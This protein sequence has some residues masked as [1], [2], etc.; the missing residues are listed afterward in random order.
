MRITNAD[1]SSV[2]GDFIPETADKFS[3]TPGPRNREENMSQLLESLPPRSFVDFTLPERSD[4]TELSMCREAGDFQ[5]YVAWLADYLHMVRLPLSPAQQS[6][7][8][9]TPGSPQGV[10]FCVRTL[11]AMLRGISP[12]LTRGSSLKAVMRNI[13][14]RCMA[15]GWR[16]HRPKSGKNFLSRSFPSQPSSGVLLLHFLNTSRFLH[17]IFLGISH[18]TG[19]LAKNL[20]AAEKVEAT[21]FIQ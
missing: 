9:S 3:V 14:R 11:T 12:R 21:R 16:I 13:M 4:G 15:F 6:W 19:S 10:I 2:I 5:T 18:L 20:I 7:L 8:D 1:I 17:A